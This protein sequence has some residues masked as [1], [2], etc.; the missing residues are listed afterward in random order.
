M[1]RTRSRSVKNRIL[2]VDDEANIRGTISDI[3]TDES[4]DVVLAADGEEAMRK[5]AQNDLDAALLDVMLPKKGGM[6]VLDFLHREYPIIPVI[7][8]S[9]HGNIR[10]AV[11]AIQHGA[12]DFIEKPLSMER[13]LSSVRNAVRFKQLQL[14]N[15]SL[16][17][18]LSSEKPVTF[19]GK[20]QAVQSLLSNFPQIAASE[21]SVL[22][23]GEN[24]TGKEVVARL[25][26]QMSPRCDEA[27]IGVN[28]AAIPENLIES[29]LF[30]YEKGAF[31]GA[32]KQKKGKFENA[33]GGTIFLD[34][35][36]DLSLSAQAKVLRVIQEREFER[37]GGTE[38]LSADVRIL[39]ATNKDLAS[40]IQAG[41][42]RS[43]LFYRL[44]V[45]PVAIPPL[46]DRREDIGLLVEYFLEEFS[47]RAGKTFTAT[48]NA[49]QL[50]SGRNW[51]GNVR[52]LR[53][54]VERLTILSGKTEIDADDV[55]R[56]SYPDDIQIEAKFDNMT[57]KDAK[58][59]FE[60]GLIINRL[61]RFNMN[62]TKTAESLD[63]ERTY[64]HRKIRELH[65]DSE[66]ELPADAVME[67]DA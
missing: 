63:I 1:N 44:N 12:I 66:V 19:V 11:D 57:L 17:S 67:A 25:I 14:E 59:D 41:R 37:V 7:I 40:E 61:I 6:D 64:L 50:V 22:I 49:I 46:R 28:C 65:I 35:V 62:I 9:G 23:T 52:E 31:T 18:R 55:L 8:I 21:A 34:E 2:V 32:N 10:M 38:L 29:E 15:I 43:D 56:Q 47:Q 39:A 45:V 51:P 5:T 48:R 30:G 13:L 42:F 54:F 27:F 20:S 24:G 33:S 36:A 3:L 16:K 58:R 26:H 4:Y 60:K 53:N